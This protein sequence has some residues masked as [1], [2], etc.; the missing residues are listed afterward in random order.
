VRNRYFDL[1]RAVAIIRVVAYHSFGLWWLTILCPAMGLMFALGGSLMAASIDKGGPGAVVRRLRRTLPPLWALGAV[2][3]VAMVIAG[4][5]FGWS[6]LLWILPLHNPPAT[7]WGARFLGIVWYLREYLWFVLLSPLLLAA[8]RRAPV[9]ALL[10]PLALLVTLTFTGWSVPNELSDFALYGTCWMI[11]FAHHDGALRRVGRRTVLAVGGVS[12][13]LGAAWFLTHP[14]P[15]GLDLND[16][17]L[18]NALWSIGFLL[19]AL[20]LEPSAEALARVPWLNRILEPV[21]ARAMTI[22]LWHSG[23]ILLTV[24][25]A[26]AWRIPLVGWAGRLL[27]AASVLVLLSAAVLLLGWIEDLAARRPL[28]LLPT[29]RD[30]PAA[31]ARGAVR[32]LTWAQARPSEAS[33][34]V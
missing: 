6:A 12:A 26:G 13:A 3:V 27:M 29:A 28:R 30:R 23:A 7:A 15:R 16:I 8:F 21:N 4:G 1:L 20:A 31:G 17:P 11:G 19:V 24:S 25:A 5:R 32:S 14:G 22:Y 34:R 9:P 10:A 2:A 33:S 18:G